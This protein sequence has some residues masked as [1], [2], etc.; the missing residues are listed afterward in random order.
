MKTPEL[1]NC[2]VCRGS[3]SSAA[4]KCPHCG[5]SFRRKSWLW[6]RCLIYA[7]VVL[8]FIMGFSAVTGNMERANLAELRRG[9]AMRQRELRWMEMARNARTYVDVLQLQDEMKEA[10]GVER[11]MILK[12][13]R[14]VNIRH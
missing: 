7:A 6:L 12:E 3:V 5:Q 8:A 4:A 13:G 1:T 2:F 9:E 11:R 10:L 14:V